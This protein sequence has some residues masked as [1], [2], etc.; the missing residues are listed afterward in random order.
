MSETSTSRSEAAV[1]STPRTDPHLSKLAAN[2]LIVQ[3]DTIDDLTSRIEGTM[4]HT[5]IVHVQ[6]VTAAHAQTV[7]EAIMKARPNWHICLYNPAAELLVLEVPSKSHDVLHTNLRDRCLQK[8]SDLN[9]GP[10]FAL[11][12]LSGTL[13]TTLSDDNSLAQPDSALRPLVRLEEIS[14]GSSSHQPPVAQGEDSE[15]RPVELEDI[16]SADTVAPSNGNEIPVVQMTDAPPVDSTP[17]A[18]KTDGKNGNT[19]KS[20][21]KTAKKKKL[22]EEEKAKELESRKKRA[23]KKKT[24]P[25]LVFEAGWSQSVLMLQTKARWWFDASDGQVR[26]VLIAKT[27]HS[28]GTII[29]EKWLASVGQCVQKIEIKPRRGGS[30]VNKRKSTLQMDEQVDGETDADEDDS[31]LVDKPASPGIGSME[32]IVPDLFE[33]HGGPIHIDFNDIFLASPGD[34]PRTENDV[35]ITEDELQEYACLV[36]KT[37]VDEDTG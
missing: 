25:S 13:W 6:Q 5:V 26:V 18:N 27:V 16:E 9:L 14:P 36:W 23:E 20:K 24:F 22:T 32:P 1:T 12:D 10:E 30:L 21:T 3:Y 11:A 34:V 28:T 35:V 2:T 31:M 8:L 15:D 33:V 4:F 19:P 17:A 29:I 7:A 37:A